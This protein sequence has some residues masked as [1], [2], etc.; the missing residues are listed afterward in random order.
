MQKATT[1]LSTKV[2][3]LEKKIWAIFM[4]EEAE[5][6]IKDI[7]IFYASAA[8][9]SSVFIFVAIHIED[10]KTE[11]TY[12]FL[13]RRQK[14][15]SQLIKRELKTHFHNITSY[16]AANEDKELLEELSTV[17][18]EMLLL[19]WREAHSFVIKGTDENI[20]TIVEAF[21]KEKK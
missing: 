7:T 9:L 1:I 15:I 17:I 13:T 3:K 8:H 4:E 16:T 18:I 12:E 11:Q 2:T 14:T 6:L 19:Y 5:T 21:F 20:K 10:N